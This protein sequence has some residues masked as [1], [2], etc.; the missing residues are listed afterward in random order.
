ML[1]G[2]KFY[3]KKK[4]NRVRGMESNNGEGAGEC[5]LKQGGPR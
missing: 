1:E 4:V 3:E 2:D 5:N